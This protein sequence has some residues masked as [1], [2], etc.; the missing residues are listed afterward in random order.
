MD[1]QQFD[2]LS[3][4]ILLPIG[5]GKPPSLELVGELRLPFHVGMICRQGN[6]RKSESRDRSSITMP[7]WSWMNCTS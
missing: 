4:I 5:E 2:T 7:S 6:D 1:F 3:D